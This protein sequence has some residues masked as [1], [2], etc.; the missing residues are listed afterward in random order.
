MIGSSEGG[1]G[2][3][4]QHISH[5]AQST[6][7]GL[8]ADSPI[9]PS[10][11]HTEYWISFFCVHTT[12]QSVGPCMETITTI[13]N[14]KKKHKM[15]NELFLFCSNLNLSPLI[16][17]TWGHLYMCKHVA[18]PTDELVFIKD[19]CTIQLDCVHLSQSLSQ[20]RPCVHRAF[21]SALRVIKWDK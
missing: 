21:W 4:C 16:Y 19:K 20:F 11:A 1:G 8:R 17:S 12:A 10:T 18:L 13:N 6:G 9:F 3:L 2:G 14:I 7:V 5:Q 15:K